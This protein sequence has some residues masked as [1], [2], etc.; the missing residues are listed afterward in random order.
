MIETSS[1]RELFYQGQVLHLVCLFVLLAA[2]LA[3]SHA[4]GFD[5]GSFLGLSTT[6]WAALAIGNAIVHQVYVWLCWRLE[7]DGRRL[8]RR[9]G[10]KAFRLYQVGFAILIILRPVLSFALGWSN[11]GSLPITPWI[12]YAVAMI[13]LLPAIYLI[14]SVARYFG[15]E[16]AFGID[17][18]DA[19][20]REMPLVRKGIFAWTPNAMYVFGF[21]VL[22]VP[23]FLF[24]SVAALIVAAFSH[25]YVWVHY[26][27]TEKPDMRRI[28]G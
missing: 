21:L 25:I 18:F 27:C 7:L 16:R 28:Y 6:V 11:R 23:A 24:Q 5:A 3:A 13:L 10:D 19:S 26:Y 9:L 1:S 15:F 2:F 17:H 12:G 4:P 14:Y 8:T 20:Y 22:W